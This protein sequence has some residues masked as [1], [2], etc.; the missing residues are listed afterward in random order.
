MKKT[1]VEQMKNGI[2]TLATSLD[3]QWFAIPG[4]LEGPLP[5]GNHPAGR[6]GCLSAGCSHRVELRPGRNGHRIFLQ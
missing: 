1:H 6:A 3:T 5:Q 4:R 2:G